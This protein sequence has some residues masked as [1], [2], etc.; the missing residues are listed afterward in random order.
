MT[1]FQIEDVIASRTSVKMMIWIPD[2]V[3]EWRLAEVCEREEVPLS[4]QTKRL[5]GNVS[6]SLNLSAR[7]YILYIY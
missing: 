2:K 1:P 4:K 3:Y 7:N 6:L 5:A